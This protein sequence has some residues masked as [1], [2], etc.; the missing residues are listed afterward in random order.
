M[1]HREVAE[2]LIVKGADINAKVMEDGWTPLIAAL[3][4][5][6]PIRLLDSGKKDVAEL[7]I[8]KGADVNARFNVDVYHNITALHVAGNKEIAELLI[9]KGLDVNATTDEGLTPLHGVIICFNHEMTNYSNAKEVIEVLL[10]QGADINAKAKDGSTP[11]HAVAVMGHRDVAELLIANGANINA[12]DKDGWTPLR[13]ALFPPTRSYSI[14]L[15]DRGKND[16]V[17]LLIT[18]GAEINAEDKEGRTPLHSA[19]SM[20]YKDVTELL[21]ANG[22]N[23]NARDKDGWTPLDRAFITDRTEVVV[24]LIAKGASNVTK[25]KTIRVAD[26][27]REFKGQFKWRNG[28]EPFTLILKIDKIEKKDG[29]FRF[30]GSHLYMPGGTRMKIEGTIDGNTRRIT[31]RE[32]DSSR[33][34]AITDGSFEGMISRNLKIIEATWTTTSTGSKGMHSLPIYDKGDLRLQAG[35]IK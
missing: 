35:R 16:V 17:E 23:I 2:L 13:A 7:L 3:F 14:I 9:S 33:A 11:L 18:K 26:I 27:P 15:P 29:A 19:A 34:D 12:R 8:A 22:A 25:G 31:I 24:S 6:Y 10:A 28:T 1:G 21:I 30:S 4:S 5:S 32:S 20:G